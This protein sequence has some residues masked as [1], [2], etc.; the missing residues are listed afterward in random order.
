MADRFLKHKLNGRIYTWDK[1]LEEN[2]DF[3]E[4][5]EEQAYP[6]RFVPEKQRQ[7]KAKVNLETKDVPEEETG[8]AD[9]DQELTKKLAKELGV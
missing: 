1:R 4:V 7:R 8:N 2:P 5:S 3:Y 6:E 9:V